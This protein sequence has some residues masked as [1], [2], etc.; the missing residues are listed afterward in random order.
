[1][2]CKTQ[3][4]NGTVCGKEMTKQEEKQD[5]MC[6]TCADNVWIEMTTDKDHYWE[7]KS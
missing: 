3:D 1:M 7:H 4:S 2:E 5:G 6:W